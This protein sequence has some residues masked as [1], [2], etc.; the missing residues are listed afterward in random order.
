MKGSLY[1]PALLKP[2]SKFVFP[3]VEIV[4]YASVLRKNMDYVNKENNMCIQSVY[5]YRE[6]MQALIKVNWGADPGPMLLLPVFV[7]S[8]NGNRH[9]PVLSPCFLRYTDSVIVTCMLY[10]VIVYLLL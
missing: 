6:H 3:D 9:F 2:Q 4:S 7:S 10:S 1:R 5:K 8:S